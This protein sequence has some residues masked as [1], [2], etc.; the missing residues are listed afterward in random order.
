MLRHIVNAHF[1]NTNFCYSFGV[2]E[3]VLQYMT[4]P[5]N[6]T[7][8]TENCVLIGIFCRKFGYF[9]ME[10]SQVEDG[11]FLPWNIY[12]NFTCFFF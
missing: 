6:E 3:N 1:A 7:S 12:T 8:T 4:L 10:I 11:R 9:L 5:D 2:Q